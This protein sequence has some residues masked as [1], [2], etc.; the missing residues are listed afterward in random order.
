MLASGRRRM[1]GK[2]VAEV[3]TV[4]GVVT[5][6]ALAARTRGRGARATRRR[7]R[8]HGACMHARRC[9]RTRPRRRCSA[10]TIATGR[11][12][13]DHCALAGLVAL[14][15]ATCRAV[16]R[17]AGASR[18]AL[19][20]TCHGRSPAT[21]RALGRAAQARATRLLLSLLA[22][23]RRSHRASAARP[24]RL[25]GAPSPSTFGNRIRPP[26]RRGAANGG[27]RLRALP[28][29]VAA[30]L[31]LRRSRATRRCSPTPS[32][33]RHRHR[34][35]A[36]VAADADPHHHRRHHRR[37]GRADRST[38][39]TAK[40]RSSIS[41]AC[42]VRK[43]YIGDYDHA[44]L[45]TRASG[46]GNS[47]RSLVYADG[48]LLSN[49]LGNGATLHAALGPGDA[50]GDR[51]R[52]RAVRPVFRRLSGQLG[53]RGGRLRDAHADAARGAREARASAQDFELYGTD[54]RFSGGAGERLVGGRAGD[55]SWWLELQ[56]P[57]QRR[58]AAL[59]RQQAGATGTR[60]A[61]ARR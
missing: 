51:A 1:Q 15:A 2:S 17:A 24:R 47:A 27:P 44:V 60:A 21:L 22:V 29:A 38:P 6:V 9:G 10:P 13:G 19:R 4:Y 50:R 34:D 14:A 41:R 28:L 3:C 31:P 55:F 23:A 18:R 11:R 8:S 52:R 32:S 53:G 30:S 46:T 12:G 48:I 25:R 43:R 42:S 40:T 35:P 45:A 56:S 7:W 58:P 59:L 16:R 37:P 36:D 33:A 20:R 57:R 61:R 5:L 54:D 39:P 49:L 26:R